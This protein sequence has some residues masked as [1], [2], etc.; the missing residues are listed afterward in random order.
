MMT[1]Y[2]TENNEDEKGHLRQKCDRRK[3]TLEKD[4]QDSR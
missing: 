2:N 1:K 4:S 3:K